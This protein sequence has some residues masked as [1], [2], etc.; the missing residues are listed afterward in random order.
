MNNDTAKITTQ[1]P[2]S[3]R[4]RRRQAKIRQIVSAATEV[5]LEDGFSA[6][7]MDKIVERAGVSKRTLYNYYDSKEDI[8]FDVMQMQLGA[9]WVSF[10][11]DRYESE[12]WGEQL[13]RIG[14]EMLRIANSPVT[15]ALFRT[16][17]AESQRFPLLAQ[18]FFDESFGKLLDAIANILEQAIKSGDIRLTDPKEAADYFLDLLTGTA[19]QSIMV[20]VKPPMNDK[21]IR[22]RTERALNYFLETFKLDPDVT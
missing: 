12:A 13:R 8:F 11:P 2:S 18:Q 15:L 6:A 9:I 3:A 17:V 1:P 4:D 20:G 7:S 19:Y 16:V 14:I 5:F 22:G 10:E 21:E